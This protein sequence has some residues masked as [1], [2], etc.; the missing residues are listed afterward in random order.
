MPLKDIMLFLRAGEPSI[1]ALSVAASIARRHDAFISA[2]CLVQA[3]EAEAADCYAI[4][5]AAVSDVLQRLDLALAS[6]VKDCHDAFVEVLGVEAPCVWC[7]SPPDEEAA[8]SAGRARLADLAILGRSPRNEGAD[9]ALA[10]AL[11]LHSGAPCL[12]VPEAYSGGARLDR[13]V[14]GWNGSAE[15][16]RAMED[17]LDLLKHASAV[18]VV[19]VGELAPDRQE[20]D[21]EAVVAHLARHGIKAR[22][23]R[24]Q[25]QADTAAAL[26]HCC[27]TL[28]ASLL[29]VGAYSHA[30][31]AEAV[32]GGVTRTLLAHCPLPVLLSR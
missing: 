10:E 19:T 15:A 13:I 5:P 9:R 29:V 23:H 3:P 8:R 27:E 2:C 28:G 32:L 12:I 20:H 30:R 1:P 26:L 22:A 6:S 31:V 17:G 14:L 7:L 18:D 11:A 4:G 25:H 24:V 16:K 21:A